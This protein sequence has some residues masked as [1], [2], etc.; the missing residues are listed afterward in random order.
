MASYYWTDHYGRRWKVCP[1][2]QKWLPA[3]EK[4]LLRRKL[5]HTC[6]DL[7]QTIGNY[8]KSANTHSEGGAFD[9]GQFTDKHL[10][11]A[12]QM[13]A[14]A[15]W[16]RRRSQGFEIDHAHGVLRGCPHNKPARY[17]IDAVDAGFNGLGRGGKKGPDDGPRPLSGR[18]WEEGIAW[19]DANAAKSTPTVT[20]A[21][22]E[23]HK[24]KW[25]LPVGRPDELYPIGKK[26]RAP[27]FVQELPEG[28]RARVRGGSA[29]TS[30]SKYSRSEG[31]EMNR[32]GSK[33]AWDSAKGWHSLLVTCHIHAL[34]AKSKAVVVGQIHDDDDD[35]VM[36]R[37][38]NGKVYAEFSKGKGKGS[39]KVP[40]GSIGLE[41]HFKYQIV[42]DAKSIRVYFR[43]L[44]AARPVMV[45]R[46][47]R[48]KGA[49]YKAGNYFQST[50]G[51]AEVV[52]HELR[53]EH[54]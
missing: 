12:R 4:E 23:L 14:D 21:P 46:R 33:A 1:C 2:L 48:A 47:R 42:A 40:L 15:T 17:Q 5:I 22:I 10:W 53:V 39:E 6:I 31:R 52:I 45:E 28:I 8:S 7:Y 43:P 30:G 13:G 19:A 51:E 32:D 44:A 38:E 35:V 50:S 20:T 41:E 37:V 24:F 49:Y 25:T 11:V 36:V 34:S 54:R 18:T 3:Y 29:H 9:S 27:W 26:E 16:R